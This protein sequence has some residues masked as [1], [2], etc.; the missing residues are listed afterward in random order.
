M[1]RL[2]AAML[3]ILPV[4]SMADYLDVIE[5]KLNEGCTFSSYL[6]ITKDFNEW[7]KANGYHAEVLR[8][9][10]RANLDTFI[11]V[12]RSANAAAFGKAWDTWRDALAN[13]DSVPAKLWARFSACSTNIKRSGFDT[14]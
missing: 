9:V 12:G 3:L 2:L 1:K 4:T 5:V 11:W 7:G 8:P 6:A 13:A 14:Y 10:Q